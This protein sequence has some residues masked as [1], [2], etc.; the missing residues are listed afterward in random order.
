MVTNL[1]LYHAEPGFASFEKSVDP[2]QLASD[3]IPTIST[4][5]VIEYMYIL[6]TGIQ[7]L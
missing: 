2:D 3:L 6:I 1:N 7:Q 4:V 5:H